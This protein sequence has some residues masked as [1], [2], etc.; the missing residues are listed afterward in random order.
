[1]KTFITILFVVLTVPVFSQFDSYTTHYFNYF[2]TLAYS[3]DVAEAVVID[4]AYNTYVAGERAKE[5]SM[6]AIEL[7]KY[8]ANGDSIIIPYVNNTYRGYVKRML[9]VNNSIFVICNAVN[10]STGNNTLLVLKYNTSLSL[11]SSSFY[12]THSFYAPED[13]T[14]DAAGNL[15]ILCSSKRGTNTNMS[16][17]KLNSSISFLDSVSYSQ[18]NLDDAYQEFPKSIFYNSSENYVYACGSSLNILNHLSAA[19]LLKYSAATLDLAW[20]KRSALSTGKNVYNSVR[21]GT[22]RVYTTGSLTTIGKN[23]LVLS[24]YTLSGSGAKTATYGDSLGNY[25]QNEGL[26]IT[27]VSPSGAVIVGSSRDSSGNKYDLLI[28]VYTSAPNVFNYIRHEIMPYNSQVNAAITETGGTYVTGRKAVG[29]SQHMFLYQFNT[30][31]GL[32]ALVYRDSII[33]RNGGGNAIAG[34]STAFNPDG[35]FFL[36]VVGYQDTKSGVLPNDYQMFSRHY[37]RFIIGFAK[38]AVTA[39]DEAIKNGTINKSSV[40]YQNAPNPFTQNTSIRYNLLPG[41]VKASIIV[42]NAA[43]N[44]VRTFVLNNKGTG[45]IT[46]HANELA[47]GSYYYTLIIDGRKVDSK[48]MILIK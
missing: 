6:H 22:S 5:T 2:S 36:R 17:V 34:K 41:T 26:K 15:Y 24:N 19:F 32:G 47:A 20:K 25:N 14:N 45:A 10:V 13:A 3:N 7:I 30:G 38:A 21:A 18:Q 8:A 11:L 33:N 29:S 40:L 43:G 23:E 39:E 27:S 46:I 4:D 48:Q 37:N 16:I 35:T 31:K 44:I 9:F 1:M 12:L 42:S 28:S